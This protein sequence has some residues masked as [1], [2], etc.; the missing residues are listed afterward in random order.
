MITVKEFSGTGGSAQSYATTLYSYDIGD[1]L[2]KVRDDKGNITNIAYDWLGRK[3]S[4]DDPNSR[5]CK[6]HCAGCGNSWLRHRSFTLDGNCSL[7]DSN[8]WFAYRDFF[9]ISQGWDLD[10]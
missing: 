8:D 6:R 2:V 3:T 10:N 9:N 7:Q 1:R 5:T 4:M